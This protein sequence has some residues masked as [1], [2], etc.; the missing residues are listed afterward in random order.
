ML[1]AKKN[2]KQKCKNKI[3]KLRKIKEIFFKKMSY[4]TLHEIVKKCYLERF[5]TLCME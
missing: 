3:V 4:H 5:I 1:Q 2:N